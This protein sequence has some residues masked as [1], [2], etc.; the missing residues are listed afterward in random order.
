MI[1][2]VQQITFKKTK[3]EKSFFDLIHLSKLLSLRPTDHNQFD[4]HGL[5]F[6]V[7]LL[8]ERGNGR[9]SINF[10]DYDYSQGTLF[11]LGPN[12]I[13]KFYES[14][15][16]GR[17]LVFTESFVYQYLNEKNAAKLFQ[18]FSQH[19]TS[20]M[21]QLQQPEYLK[22][23]DLIQ[24]VE[25]EFRTERDGFSMELIRSFLHIIITH[26]IRIKSYDNAMLSTS[27]RLEQFLKYQSLVEEHCQEHRKVSYYAD[28][29]N[30]TPRTLNNI[31]NSTLKKSA[32]TVIEEVMVS[33][34]KQYLI[35]TSLYV[36]QIAYECG[37]HEPSHLTKFFS[38]HTGLTPKRFRSLFNQ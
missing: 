12:N 15:A 29:L 1:K 17:I 2:S 24:A 32:K 18:L 3:G 9:H 26:I 5:T 16:E 6:F 21:L 10:Q 20:P 11:L 7:L 22:I 27:P 34:I 14:E 33:R 28:L 25:N 13:H 36:S 30:I 19:L 38:K 4:H 23:K 8:I 35:N 31:T 37:F